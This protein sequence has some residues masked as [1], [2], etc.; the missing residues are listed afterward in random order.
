MVRKMVKDKAPGPNDFSIGFFQTYRDVI[1]EDLLKV[2]HDFFSFE[3]FEKSLT[4]TFLVLILKKS[5]ALK[6]K[7]YRP[8]SLVSRV[9]KII[10]L[11]VE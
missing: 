2:F 4:A 7:D 8:I 5:G 10:D 1:K 3:K 9:Y 11:V 6:V